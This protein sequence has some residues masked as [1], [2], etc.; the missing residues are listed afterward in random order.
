MFYRWIIFKEDMCYM[1]KNPCLM[2][3][4]RKES[5]SYSLWTLHI[6]LRVLLCCFL[7]HVPLLGLVEEW[8]DKHK[9]FIHWI[10][11]ICQFFCFCF[12]FCFF[13]W[14]SKSIVFN[15]TSTAFVSVWYILFCRNWLQVPLEMSLFYLLDNYLSFWHSFLFV[16]PPDF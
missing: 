13:N 4:Q 14:S 7:I 5:F 16:F 9:C 1:L 6:T 2:S 10:P 15:I 3:S 12:C 8:S 11:I